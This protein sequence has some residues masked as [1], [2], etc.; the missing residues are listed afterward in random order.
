VCECVCNLGEC[1]LC[2]DRVECVTV[3]SVWSGEYV[4]CRECVEHVEREDSKVG[5][6]TTN[7]QTNTKHEQKKQ[8]NPLNKNRNRT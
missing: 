4:G 1:K 8:T 6:P 5:T 2:S 7:K 3:W